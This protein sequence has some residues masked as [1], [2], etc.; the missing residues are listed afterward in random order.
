MRLVSGLG[1]LDKTIK[2]EDID[3]AALHEKGSIKKGVAGQGKPI[4]NP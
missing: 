3:G 4:S 2:E 1:R